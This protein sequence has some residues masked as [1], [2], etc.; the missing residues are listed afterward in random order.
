[1]QVG[2]SFCTLSPFTQISVELRGEKENWFLLFNSVYQAFF[3]T[4]R[5]ACPIEK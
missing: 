4:I 3:V 5:R 1:M 2:R